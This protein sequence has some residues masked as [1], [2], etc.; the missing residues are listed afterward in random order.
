MM[1]RLCETI[2]VPTMAALRS[3]R[4]ASAADLVELRLDLLRDEVDVAGALA[5]RRKP[6]IVTCRP[7]WEGGHFAGSEEERKRILAEA[8]ALGAEFVDLEWRAGFDDLL[9]SAAGQRIVLSTHDFDRVPPDLADRCREMR[10]TGAAVVKVA[11]M[12]R[13]LGDL[14]ALAELGREMPDAAR[15]V[16][17]MG[18]FG[19]VSRLLPAHFHSC[20]TYAGEG[21]APGQLSTRRMLEEFGTRRA[22]AHSAI[23]GI[24]GGSVGHSL[25]PAM[26]NAAFR[27]AGVDALYVPLPI[28]GVEDFARFAGA[29]PVAGASVTHPFKIDVFA[30]V[31]DPDPVCRRIGAV[32]TLKRE[33]GRWLATNTDLRG[34]LAPLSS[35][36]TRSHQR[37]S[38]LGAGGAARAVAV[39][40]ASTG[41]RVTVH[42][43]R[44]D[45]AREVAALA[46]G[47]VGPWPP[48]P[49]SWDLLVN[50]TPVGS[51]PAT[52]ETPFAGPF[53]GRL[54]YD[55][56]YHPPQ[57]RLLREA[58]TAGCETLG[59]L[60][61]LVAQAQAQSE[62]WTGVRP[63]DR[64]L[65]EA[66]LARLEE[67]VG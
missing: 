16:L 56:V 48:A 23:Y 21:A 2:A 31:D 36:V 34:F 60:D 49:G 35:R 50:T 1:P 7:V 43:R 11:A 51:S 12:P 55:L 44:P 54:V 30:L 64:L 61:M 45:R 41:S 15:V 4:D 58:A 25:S 52:D 57:T 19:V 42:A 62:W 37:A 22:S 9:A 3:A 20:W 5:G 13:A 66:A 26:H 6:V 47:D 32:N 24:V 40:L 53:T 67:Q 29:F 59:G 14:V 10:R 38:V 28:V 65:R 17:G 27:A 33:D 8:L 39:A 63:P 46:G 18:E